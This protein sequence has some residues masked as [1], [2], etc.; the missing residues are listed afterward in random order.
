MTSVPPWW[1]QSSTL[2]TSEIYLDDVSSTL[3]TSALPWWRQWWI[4]WTR[5]GDPQS[6]T[7]H[8]TDRKDVARNESNPS[9]F[10]ILKQNIYFT[11]TLSVRYA[12]SNIQLDRLIIG[13]KFIYSWLTNS[14]ETIY[15]DKATNYPCPSYPVGTIPLLNTETESN[16]GNWSCLWGNWGPGKR[17]ELVIEEKISYRDDAHSKH[18]FKKTYLVWEQSWTLRESF[19]RTPIYVQIYIG[20]YI[21]D[22][23]CFQ[24]I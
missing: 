12:W 21:R 18:A 10:G 1:R 4:C 19:L 7:R 2:T 6:A 24:L 17:T 23:F 22:T 20:D 8:R 11:V 16:S 14:I 9:S 13:V 3:M 5:E 15:R